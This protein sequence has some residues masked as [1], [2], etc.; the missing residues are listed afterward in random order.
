MHVVIYIF[1]QLL[2]SSLVCSISGR[3]SKVVS[4]NQNFSPMQISQQECN[5]ANMIKL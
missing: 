3:D 2:V 1:A 4:V 5:Q